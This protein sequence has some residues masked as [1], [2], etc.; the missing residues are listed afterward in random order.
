[1]VQTLKITDI[2]VSRHTQVL[3]QVALSNCVLALFK[4][5]LQNAIYLHLPYQQNEPSSAKKEIKFQEKRYHRG[6]EV[7]FK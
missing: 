3:G 4:S 7:Y 6:R 2:V 1:M 5:A